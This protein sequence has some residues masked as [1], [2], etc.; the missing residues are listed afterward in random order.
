M[1]KLLMATCAIACVSQ[2]GTSESYASDIYVHIN[3]S[4][5]ATS[6]TNKTDDNTEYKC[7]QAKWDISED[8]ANLQSVRLDGSLSTM[9]ERYEV[10]PS[11]IHIIA[12]LPGKHKGKT[13]HLGTSDTAREAG[14]FSGLSYH[15]SH[16]RDPNDQSSGTKIF[17]KINFGSDGQPVVF[18]GSLNYL[19]YNS[20]IIQCLNFK[21]IN[22]SEVTSMQS[23]FEN[24][25]NLETIDF[26]DFNTKNVTAMSCMFRRCESLK[27]LNLSMFNTQKVTSMSSMFYGCQ[28]LIKLDLNSFD[29]RNV[30]HMSYMFCNCTNL[31]ELTAGEYFNTSNV[32]EMNNMFL[33]CKSIKEIDLLK[34]FNTKNVYE[35]HGMFQDC[36]ALEKLD[37]SSF[38]SEHLCDVGSMFYRCPNL[39]TEGKLPSAKLPSEEEKGIKWGEFDI[40]TVRDYEKCCLK[41]CEIAKIKQRHIK[42]E[43][44]GKKKGAK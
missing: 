42:I 39:S 33:N 14:A 8:E 41:D 12:N 27:N 34:R 22:T 16:W 35:M 6:N 25:I 31:L 26:G 24:C 21:N 17:L 2:G 44:E 15:N 29:T 4:T 3:L 20:N 43:E 23:M 18:H 7:L 32:R 37:L 30:R 5:I 19:F 10:P 1:K 40:G 28:S 38:S 11:C 9:I 13:V 36:S